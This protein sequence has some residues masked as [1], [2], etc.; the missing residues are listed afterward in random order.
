MCHQPGTRDRDQWARSRT[1]M[2]PFGFGAHVGSLLQAEGMV[3][4]RRPANG[5]AVTIHHYC[6]SHIEVVSLA[7]LSF[8]SY[9]GNTASLRPSPYPRTT[10][11]GPY[12]KRVRSHQPWQNPSLYP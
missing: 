9:F 10:S 7:L 4:T 3:V 5:N 6:P 11:P 1:V 12:S 2:I 8:S